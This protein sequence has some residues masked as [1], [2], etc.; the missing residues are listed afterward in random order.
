M[1]VC[2]VY[3]RAA[4]AQ[5]VQEMFLSGSEWKLCPKRVLF[6]SLSFS[7]HYSTNTQHPPEHIY[8]K[9][10][11]IALY[12]LHHILDEISHQQ[13]RFDDDDVGYWFYTWLV[14]VYGEWN[15]VPCPCA[16]VRPAIHTRSRANARARAYTYHSADLM[17]MPKRAWACF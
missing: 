17:P 14:Y 11:S 10:C 8:S 2:C 12:R 4:S 16:H 9:L 6:P 5:M 15:H 7:R 13:R 3:T 1:S